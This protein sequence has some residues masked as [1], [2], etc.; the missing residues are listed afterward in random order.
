MTTQVIIPYTTHRSGRTRDLTLLRTLRMLPLE[1]MPCLFFPFS[2]QRQSENEQIY[3]CSKSDYKITIVSIKSRSFYKF[4]WRGHFVTQYK[5]KFMD[6]KL[7]VAFKKRSTVGFRL[8]DKKNKLTIN[9]MFH[10]N[11]VTG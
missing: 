3:E 9:D 11:L 1:I 10:R 6:T 8:E 5:S 4:N 7:N 2:V